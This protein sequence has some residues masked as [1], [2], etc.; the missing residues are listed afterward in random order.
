[1]AVGGNR[2]LFLPAPAILPA[3]RPADPLAG[4][5]SDGMLARGAHITLCGEA[6]ADARIVLGWIVDDL[7]ADVDDVVLFRPVLAADPH[8]LIVL[9]PPNVASCARS[10]VHV[11]AIIGPI[12]PLMLS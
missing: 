1:L 7:L 3:R 4:V 11:R 10:Q 9:R 12:P 5:L 6:V 2:Q 8:R